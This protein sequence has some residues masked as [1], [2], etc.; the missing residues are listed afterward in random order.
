MGLLIM[1]AILGAPISAAAY[2][3]L[4]LVDE[5]QTWL[6]TDLPKG[7]G[8]TSEPKW[9]PLPLLA[10]CGVLVGLAVRYLPGRGGHSPADGFKAGAGPAKPIDLPGIFF[11]ALATL[12]LG[13]VLGPEAPLI[14]L[15]GGLAVVAVRLAKRNAPQQALLVLAAAGS[16]AAVSTL[17]GSPLLGAFLL[18]E[19]S[20]LGGPTLGLVLLPGLLASGIGL[21]IFIGLNDW[22]GLGTQSLTIPG[23]PPVGQPDLAQFGWALGIGLAAAVV[24]S[25]IRW[26]GLVLR[27]H[28][29]R[30]L[31]LLTP[32]MGLVVA[33]LAIAYA[34]GTGHSTSDVLF[35]GQNELGPLLA[36]S[37]G[38]SVGALVL[39]TVCKGL[40]YG[41]S[42]SSFRGGPVFPAMFLG[43][44]GGI[45]LSHFDGLPLVAGVAMG[46]GAMSV[47][48]LRLPLTSVLLA[49]LLLGANSLPV[50]PVVIVA[51][52]V[53]HVA[54]AR[55]QARLVTAGSAA[56]PPPAHSTDDTAAAPASRSAPP[57]G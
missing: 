42:L 40:A 12:G 51:V 32:V 20:G 22:T 29:E 35:S 17:L 46:I 15:G 55:L 43:A 18:M 57:A 39:L 26:L 16:F 11:A 38:Y 33:G 10:L 7:L 13:A 14:A 19:A 27:P 8:F 49:T 52:T 53:A 23:L 3:F 1:A 54:A 2:G 5:L 6:F 9:W 21:L 30:R 34:E 47:A 31:L 56:V 50:M 45:A 48:M 24:G 28:V 25:S 41:V 44:A 36:G 4:E 37:A